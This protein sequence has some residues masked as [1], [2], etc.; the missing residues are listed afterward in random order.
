MK[1]LAV[2]SFGIL[3]CVAQAHTAVKERV[4]P[5]GEDDAITIGESVVITEDIQSSATDEQG[6]FVSLEAAGDDSTFPTYVEGRD[7]PGSFAIDFDGTSDRLLGLSFDPRNFGSFAALSQAWIKPDSSASGQRQFIWGLGS[8]NGGVGIS[9]DGFWE[10][11]ASAIVDDTVSTI[12]VAFDD[13]THVAVFRGGNGASLYINGSVALREGGFWNGPGEISVGARPAESEFFDGTLDDFNLAGFSDGVF[14]VGADIDFF[15]DSGFVFT[16]VTGDVDQ[17]GLVTQAD[18]DLWSQNVGFDNG[19]GFGDP[20]TLVL[21]DVDNNGRVNFFDFEIIKEQAAIAGEPLVLSVP[22]PTAVILLIPG[23]LLMATLRKTRGAVAAIVLIAVSL[24]ASGRLNAE[25][26]VADDFFYSQP[27]KV[28][29]PGGGFTLQDYSGGQNGLG[30]WLNDW[31]SV[32][33]G[34]ITGVDLLPDQEPHQALVGGGLSENHLD[35][36]VSFA[37]LADD[38]TIYF[39]ATMSVGVESAAIGKIIL[40]A[41]LSETNEIA[42]GFEAGGVTANLGTAIDS[43]GLGDGL[44]NDGAFHQM[45]GRFE[46]NV[47]G[48]N[49]RLTLWLDPTDIETAET[50]LSVE[51]DVAADISGLD[52]LL[53]LR[54]LAD[55]TVLFDDL[56]VATTWETAT[57]LAIPRLDLEVSDTSGV[58]TLVNNTG[59]DFDFDYYEITS[60]DG[61][62]VTTEFDGVEEQG[63]VTN[64]A[65][66]SLIVESNLSA[67]T[68]LAAGAELVL[69]RIVD[70]T[71]EPELTVRLATTDSLMNLVNVDFVEGGGETICGDFDLDGDI[72]SADRTIQTVG[73]TGAINDGSGMATFANGDCDGDGDVDTADATG[74]I[75][76]WT[77]ALEGALP[78]SV[79]SYELSSTV[80]PEPR[81]S[82]V[83][84]LSVL[85]GIA[86]WRRRDFR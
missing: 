1:R 10:L 28:L 40:N 72:D 7:G 41:P 77:G 5:M 55:G 71:N 79:E 50:T 39:G 48:A 45:V 2:V 52:G 37:G 24:T 20:G 62:L 78:A 9:E 27:S 12:P 65:T 29:G 64:S 85:L 80:V 69:G 51:A 82:L 54:R 74:L 60:A 47:D 59:I 8:D 61:A 22:E 16:D 18:Y 31:V 70:P 26:I 30:V 36:N 73:W 4:Y 35:R 67:S 17:D 25:V 53:Q 19:F 56:A 14:D 32:G 6:G 58:A 3:F 15:P 34:I 44:V 57:S 33:D 66:E 23:L 83:L 81:A 46:F 68:S 43:F 11:V 63:W 38:Q 42:I 21:G 13:W 84:T 75:A 49:D 76:N 86:L